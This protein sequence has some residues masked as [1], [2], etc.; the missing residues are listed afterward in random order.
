MVSQQP[1][2]LAPT[3]SRASVTVIG[4]TGGL[5]LLVAN[6]LVAT[7]DVRSVRLLS[8]SGRLSCAGS[9]YQQLLA[10]GV[11][12]TATAADCGTAADSAQLTGT[13]CDVVLHA[14]GV[15][16]VR[17]CACKCSAVSVSCCINP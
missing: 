16:Q 5:G 17:T 4:G 14:G 15:L 9:A 1:T 13:A 3:R 10:A 2:G 6:W 11:G 12:I 7:G 8:R